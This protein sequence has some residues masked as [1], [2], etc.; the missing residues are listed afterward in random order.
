MVTYNSYTKYIPHALCATLYFFFKIKKT[1]KNSIN[2]DK[3]KNGIVPG[4]ESIGSTNTEMQL[5]LFQK[6]KNMRV[7]GGSAMASLINEFTMRQLNLLKSLFLFSERL[8][9]RWVDK[10]EE[11]S[12]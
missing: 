12:Q 7:I 10:T 6:K 11:G 8:T 9:Y 4:F 2:K 1:P 5:Q 3:P